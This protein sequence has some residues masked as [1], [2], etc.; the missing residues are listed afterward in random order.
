LRVQAYTTAP[1]DG[2]GWYLTDPLSNDS[3]AW[4][5]A[6]IERRATADKELSEWLEPVVSRAREVSLHPEALH[7]RRDRLRQHVLERLPGG[8]SEYTALIDTLV[9][10]EGRYQANVND[11]YDASL[12]VSLSDAVSALLRD[13]ARSYPTDKLAESLPHRDGRFRSVMLDEIERKLGITELP[14][15][16]R[17]VTHAELCA[18]CDEHEGP[19][20]ALLLGALLVAHRE[21][22]HPLHQACR[23]DLDV[24]QKLVK[25][26]E[27]STRDDLYALFQVLV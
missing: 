23:D 22:R 24:V 14:A 20:G 17:E 18:A 2:S 3:N 26:S 10:V 4:L 1:E 15:S 21:P 27:G 16:V 12:P 8:A 9:A 5:R 13:W 11:G 7:E 19:T 25:A 6:Q